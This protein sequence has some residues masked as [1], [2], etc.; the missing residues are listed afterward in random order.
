MEKPF[1]KKWWFTAIMAILV[2]FILGAIGSIFG[3]S[4][5]KENLADQKLEENEKQGNIGKEEEEKPE[6]LEK[7]DEDEEVGEE[8]K[9]S[10]EGDT[11]NSDGVDEN[12][13]SKWD[14]LKGE[15]IGKSD[16]DFK[17]L[18]NLNPLEVTNDP[19]GNLRIIILEESVSIEEYGLSYGETY[20][21]ESQVHFIINLKDKTTTILTKEDEL[22]YVDIREY[23]EKEEE[24]ESVLGSGELLAEYIIYPDGDIEKA[25]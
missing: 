22:I 10:T 6:N 15:I 5:P 12:D 25:N 11:E 4:E 9:E 13:D 21:D 1:Y 3:G 7:K 16:K 23:I 24:D 19:T 2:I 14:E 17:T 20:I 18:T 8:E